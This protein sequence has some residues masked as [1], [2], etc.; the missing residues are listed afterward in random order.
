[1]IRRGRVITAEFDSFYLVAAYVPNSSRGLVR[2]DYRQRW[3]VDFRAYL[4][5]LDSKKPLILCGD[6]NVA[7]QEIDLK[8]PKTN[9]K[10]PGFTPQEREGF[11]ALLDE[12]FID[13]FRQLYPDKQYAYTF[14]TYMMNARGK[15]VGWRLD[16]LCPVKSIASNLV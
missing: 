7:H 6:L 9:K 13:S 10:T 1:M 16:L 12:G 4:K 8:N 3:D 11:G 5:G 2:L 14:W 15:N